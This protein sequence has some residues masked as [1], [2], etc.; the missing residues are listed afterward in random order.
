[1]DYQELARSRD[2]TAAERGNVRALSRLINQLGPMAHVMRG[3][4]PADGSIPD[5]NTLRELTRSIRLLAPHLFQESVGFPAPRQIPGGP[6]RLRGRAAPSTPGQHTLRELTRSI[7]EILPEQ[8]PE[9]LGQRP[10]RSAPRR[11]FAFTGDPDAPEYRGEMLGVQSSNVHSIGFRWNDAAPNRGTLMV[12]FLHK[13]KGQPAGAG[14]L[15]EY[16][17]VHPSVFDTMRSAA[18]KGKFV[19]DR[20]RIR[21]TVSGH[22]YWYAL[23]QLHSSGYVPRK[24]VRYGDR[25]YFVGRQVTGTNTRTGR[26]RTLTSALPDQFAQQVRSVQIVPGG[27]RVPLMQ[28]GG[29]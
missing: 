20:L 18:S 27:R 29:R 14:S 6:R 8:S 12:R 13:V 19:W 1:M 10:L 28:R 17:G 4:L 7:R 25:E 11:P 2:L 15:Y 16:S 5:R 26:T 9:T 22:R 23:R 21:G 3:F 24:A